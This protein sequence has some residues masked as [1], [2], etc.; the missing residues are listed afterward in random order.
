MS[1][2][3]SDTAI[4]S[5]I[6]KNGAPC[7]SPLDA[8]AGVNDAGTPPVDAAV[9]A[10]QDASAPDPSHDAAAGGY[11][12]A[13]DGTDAGGAG[14]APPGGAGATGGGGGCGCSIPTGIDGGPAAVGA[15]AAL[16]FAALRRRRSPRCAGRATGGAAKVDA[17]L[18]ARGEERAHLRAGVRGQRMRGEGIPPVEEVDVRTDDG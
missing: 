15:V 7:G 12:E 17:H 10:Q 1:A 13:G 4:A 16:A 18:Q 11:V 2:L 8:G 14:A 9:D 6:V 3:S 5:V